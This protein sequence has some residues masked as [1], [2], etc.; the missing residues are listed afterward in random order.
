MDIVGYVVNR[1][2][3]MWNVERMFVF[4]GVCV[5]VFKGLLYIIFLGGILER[6]VFRFIVK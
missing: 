3:G 2:I 4:Y 1:L 6:L 5:G